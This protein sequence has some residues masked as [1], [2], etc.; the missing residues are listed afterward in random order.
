MGEVATKM[1]TIE[2][3]L[4]WQ[5]RREDRF[6]LVNGVAIK[7]MTGASRAHDRIVTNVIIALGS[8]LKGSRCRPTTADIGLRTG[9]HSLRRPDVTVTC[10]EPRPD[11]Y[12]SDDPRMVVEVLSSS[13]KGIAWQKKLEEYHCLEGLAY[14]LLIDSEAEQVLVM[15]RAAGV[16]KHQDFAGREAIIELEAIGCRL[17]LSDVFEGLT[18]T[19]VE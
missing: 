15:T 3:F 9:E 5:R 1:M 8:Q 10:D 19:D 4:A 13:N 11:R 18:F 16:W 14:I 2:M 12:T 17:A 6:E 7:L